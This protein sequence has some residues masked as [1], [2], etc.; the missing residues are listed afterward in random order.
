MQA[1]VNDPD[2]LYTLT[3]RI[4][5]LR[6]LSS[7]CRA[8]RRE[9]RANGWPALLRDT[10]RRDDIPPVPADDLF[11]TVTAIGVDEIG[12]RKHIADAAD[13]RVVACATK[14]DLRRRFV[15]LVLI[16]LLN[17]IARTCGHARSS[18][19]GLDGVAGRALRSPRTVA[20]P[21]A[22]HWACNRCNGEAGEW[23]GR[24]EADDHVPTRDIDQRTTV[25]TR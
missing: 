4:R 5:T 3:A 22:Q 8:L 15:L 19:G 7:T 20:S 12:A 24:G 13:A 9:V 11:L 21:T 16:G 2:R 17:R 14:Y 1:V 23:R 10:V 18:R 6:A 25:G